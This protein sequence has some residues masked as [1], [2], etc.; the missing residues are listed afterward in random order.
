MADLIIK[1]PRIEKEKNSLAILLRVVIE[2][3]ETD[4]GQADLGVITIINH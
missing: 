1:Y 3:Q 4:T 2:E